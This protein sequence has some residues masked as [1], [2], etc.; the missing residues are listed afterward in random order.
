[1]Y[2]YDRLPAR[3]GEDDREGLPHSVENMAWISPF[4][5]L[6]AK[7]GNVILYNSFWFE[8]YFGLDDWW[9]NWYHDAIMRDGWLAN[10]NNYLMYEFPSGWRVGVFSKYWYTWDARETKWLVGLGPSFPLGDGFRCTLGIGW[11]L[12]EVNYDGVKVMGA[13]SLPIAW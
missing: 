13:L 12:R 3:Y 6:K 2:R 4:F 11:H 7:F 10:I 5:V 1:M 8:R 9:M